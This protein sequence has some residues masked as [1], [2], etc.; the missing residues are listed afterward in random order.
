MT[1]LR[2]TVRAQEAVDA[3]ALKRMGAMGIVRPAPNALQVIVGSTAEALAGEIR[4]ALAGLPE[5]AHDRCGDAPA[6]DPP[7]TPDTSAP[8]V[9]APEESLIDNLLSALGGRA[10]V[11]AVEVAAS[12]LRVSVADAS[13]VDCAALGRLGLR[14]A[15]VVAPQCVHV[16]VGP[17]AQSA[18]GTL[19]ERI[20]L[21]P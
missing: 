8:P 18:C 19:R 13:G 9:A 4:E 5:L 20:G 16:I 3:Q 6:P 2:L 10:N 17:A 12:R 7:H 11:C 1:R 14:G 15:A 21:P